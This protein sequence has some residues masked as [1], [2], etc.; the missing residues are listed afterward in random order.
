MAAAFWILFLLQVIFFGGTVSCP[1]NCDCSRFK[2]VCSVVFDIDELDLD[3]ELLVVKGV[4]R[5]RHYL[6]LDEK[7]YL[8]KEL[9][10]CSCRS[11][12]NCE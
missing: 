1:L 5:A 8:K 7:P 3:T 6:Q 2:S 12:Q 4:L 10:D 11:L 9:Q